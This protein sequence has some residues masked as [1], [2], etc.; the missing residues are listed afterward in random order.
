MRLEIRSRKLLHHRMDPNLFQLP[1]RCDE[2]LHVQNQTRLRDLSGCEVVL[3]RSASV[4]RDYYLGMKSLP[5]ILPAMWLR[6][7]VPIDG[8]YIVVQSGL[9]QHEL[10][11]T[12]CKVHT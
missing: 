5:H 9:A 8:R 10:F 1:D 6:W 12:S 4:G 3:Q 7:N 11:L 2:V